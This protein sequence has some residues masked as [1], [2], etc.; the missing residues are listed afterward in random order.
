MITLGLWWQF[1]AALFIG[2]LIGMERE[3]IQQHENDAAFAG[4][5]TYALVSLL[6]AVGAYLSTIGTEWVFGVTFV[7][8]ILLVISGYVLDRI[9]DDGKRPGIT[10]EVTLFLTFLLGAMIAWEQIILAVFIGVGVVIVL[11]LKSR[12]HRIVRGMSADD[13]RM[14]LQFALISGVILPIL[15]NQTYD[16]F[17][18]L[19]PYSIWLLVVMVSGV[20]FI[21]YVLM[22]ILGAERGIGLMGVLGGLVSSTATTV[23]L[24]G[25]SKDSPEHASA[26]ARGILLASSVMFAR[27]LVLVGITSPS[28]VQ[29]LVAPFGA[30]FATG[31]FIVAVMTVRQRQ[32]PKPENAQVTIGNPLKMSTALSFAAIYTVIVIGIKLIDQQFGNQGIYVASLITGLI[33]ADA[34]ALGIAGLVGTGQMAADVGVGA[35][36][37]ASV[38]NSLSKG[39]IA[40]TLGHPKLRQQVLV[41]LVGVAIMG[42]LVAFFMR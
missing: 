17:G 2:A 31:L 42:G 3:F 15:P 14:A 38:M 22:K 13:L 24:S 12:I 26:Y 37:L 36:V 18:V 34:I 25:A 41:A 20:G 19:N 30:M 27:I 10:S 23:S 16:P 29:V 40:F 5:R 9:H 21:G 28:F 7:A 4:I 39:V 8:L 32:N 11:S 35:V 6:G 33:D 1:I